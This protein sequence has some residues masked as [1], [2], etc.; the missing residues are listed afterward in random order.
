MR[1][2]HREIES[3]LRQGRNEASSYTHRE[4]DTC[5]GQDEILEVH[6]LADVSP[7]LSIEDK[8]PVASLAGDC[9]G[10]YSGYNAARRTY[11]EIAKR[12]LE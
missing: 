10:N 11:V 3:K 2:I 9:V 12:I 4:I 8:V 6:T 7:F 1:F 5:F